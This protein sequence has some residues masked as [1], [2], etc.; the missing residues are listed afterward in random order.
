[1]GA[2]PTAPD[3]RGEAARGRPHSLGLQHP[4]GVDPPPRAPPARWHV[5]DRD[6]CDTA[7][8]GLSHGS[9][10]SILCLSRW[11]EGG[12]FCYGAR[13]GNMGLGR[14]HMH[15][16]STNLHANWASSDRVRPL[17]CACLCVPCAVAHACASWCARVVNRK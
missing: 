6:S 8:R 3:L 4:E 14:G 16:T 1:M 9:S 2:R 11:H 15:T 12:S 13:V 17:L 7:W 5:S 10:S